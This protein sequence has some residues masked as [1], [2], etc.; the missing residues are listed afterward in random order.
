MGIAKSVNSQTGS[1]LV[2]SLILLLVITIL[3]LANIRTATME[4]RMSTSAKDRNL[5][6]Q[7]AE[8]ALTTV[9][10]NLSLN[11]PLREDVSNSCVGTTC[12]TS[13]C[14]N[15]GLCFDGLFDTTDITLDEDI[16]CKVAPN[17]GTATRVN[18]WSDTGIDVWDDTDDKHSTILFSGVKNNKVKYI[19]EFLCFVAP[20]GV[21]FNA[22]NPNNGEPLFR[23]TAFAEGQ[24][25]A[26]VMLQSTYL[27]IGAF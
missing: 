23:I 13:T 6:F 22:G 9:E 5:A 2:V 3:G 4:M 17:A 26:Q 12:F 11:P 7:A 8:A 19:T 20:T 18:F 24:S 10:K 1:V 15:N 21:V 25:G 14:E 16:E 27:A